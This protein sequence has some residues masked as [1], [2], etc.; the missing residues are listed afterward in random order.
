MNRGIYLKRFATLADGRLSPERLRLVREDV[1][2]GEPPDASSSATAA[3]ASA[4]AAAAPPPERV[5]LA[6]GDVVRQSGG[7][8]GGGGVVARGHG[9]VVVFVV[10]VIGD[11]PVA[12]DARQSL[13]GHE[14]RVLPAADHDSLGHGALVVV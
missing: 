6:R 5:V 9:A 1:I 13:V 4:A 8:D 12:D 14:V 3:T 11:V 10:G 7:G 2:D